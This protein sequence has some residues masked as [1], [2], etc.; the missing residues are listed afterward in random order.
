M[1]GWWTGEGRV[2]DGGG[3]GCG[4]VMGGL[5][6]GDGWVMDGGGWVVDG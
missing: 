5:W 1:G 6:M 4:R 2:M 3:V